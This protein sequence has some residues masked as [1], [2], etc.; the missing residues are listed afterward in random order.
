MADQQLGHPL[1][2]ASVSIGNGTTNRSNLN[3]STGAADA[4]FDGD[5][6]DTI[7]AM[8]TRLAAIDGTFYSTATLNKLSYNDMVYA[9]RT[10]DDPTTIKQ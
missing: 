1:G 8:K 4:G 9:I 5:N 2:F 7:A 10:A 6:Y 3:G